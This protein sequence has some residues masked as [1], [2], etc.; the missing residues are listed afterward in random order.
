MVE[1]LMGQ[2]F[3][4]SFLLVPILDS[5]LSHSIPIHLCACVWKGEFDSFANL[6]A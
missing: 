5:I 3:S 2:H 1:L 6:R 4:F